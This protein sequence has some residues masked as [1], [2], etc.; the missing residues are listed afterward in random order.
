MPGPGWAPAELGENE[1]A[2]ALG[3]ERQHAAD[4]QYR[5]KRA[6]GEIG[7]QKAQKRLPKEI[8]D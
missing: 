8:H 4:Q 7:E 3:I 5:R 1:L 2:Q 6:E